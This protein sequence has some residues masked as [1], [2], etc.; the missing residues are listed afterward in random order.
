MTLAATLVGASIA[1]GTSLIVE[2]RKARHDTDAEWLRSRRDIYAEY[3]TVLAQ[4]RMDLA[5]LAHDSELPVADRPTTAS[6]IFGPCYQVRHRLELYMPP[7]VEGPALTY[8]RTLRRFRTAVG[9]NLRITDQPDYDDYAQEV[10]HALAG[11]RDAMRADIDPR[12]SRVRSGPAAYV[13]ELGRSLSPTEPR[14]TA[15][16]RNR[17]SGQIRAHGVAHTAAVSEEPD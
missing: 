2:I 15:H 8:F 10:K 4:A 1:M 14:R 17:V 5:A 16:T 12:W 3:L 6:Q 9:A 13:K 7:D 11:C